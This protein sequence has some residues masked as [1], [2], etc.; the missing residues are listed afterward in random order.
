LLNEAEAYADAGATVPELGRLP[1][2]L[3]WLGRLVASG[4]LLVARIITNRQRRFNHEV[5]HGLRHV[6]ELTRQLDAANAAQ[7]ALLRHSLQQQAAQQDR[8]AAVAEH[9]QALRQQDGRLQ[10]AQTA[11]RH[12]Q[13]HLRQ[14]HDFLRAFHERSAEQETRLAR[15]EEELARLRTARTEP[16]RRE[17]AA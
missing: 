15:L 4:V 2:P 14:L 6:L 8:L 17:N 7:H 10:Q 1:Q 12:H 13:G 5:L 9:E 11:V 16:L 3:R